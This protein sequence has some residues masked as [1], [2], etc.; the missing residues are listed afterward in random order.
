MTPLP[1]TLPLAINPLVPTGGEVVLAALALVHLVLMIWAVV[2]ALN[3]TLSPR[4]RLLLVL[5]AVL[6]PMAGPLAALVVARRSRRRLQLA[7]AH[8][9]FS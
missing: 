7:T 2:A 9:T 5:L 3:A 8:A 1:L 6:V 4:H